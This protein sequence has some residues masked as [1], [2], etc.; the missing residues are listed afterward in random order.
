[1]VSSSNDASYLVGVQ[2][3]DVLQ[4]R[5][6]ASSHRGSLEMKGFGFDRRS[7][8]RAS[9]VSDASRAFRVATPSV[10]P[11]VTPTAA[12]VASPRQLRPTPPSDAVRCGV[13]GR[14]G[15]VVAG[16]NRP[17][18][19]AR[20]KRDDARLRTLRL[21]AS[22]CS[23]QRSAR[24]RPRGG[25]SRR[26]RAAQRRVEARGRGPR[27]RA[28][29]PRWP[30]RRPPRRPRPPGR[31]RRSRRSAPT[32]PS[33]SRPRICARSGKRGSPRRGRR[34]SPSPRTRGATRSATSTSPCRAKS[35]ARNSPRACSAPP[36]SCAARR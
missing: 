16:E 9:E 7:R 1:M 14:R 8:A 29:E 13:G 22:G 17:K 5:H 26:A 23:R 25:T 35:G 36:R 33:A 27:R 30:R 28:A 11:A 4:R 18:D 19:R 2:P 3:V 34:T 15:P 21:L 20:Q 31:P 12:P 6:G 10:R 24:V 32:T